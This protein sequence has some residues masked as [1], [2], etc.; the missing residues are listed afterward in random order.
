VAVRHAGGAS[1]GRAL[2][3]QDAE[4]RAR[5]RR[6]VMA[7]RGRLR[8]AL[9]DAAQAVTFGIRAAGRAMLRR[10]GAYER[11]QLR[12]LHA[13]RRDGHPGPARRP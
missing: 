4:M 11:A 12:A 1:V 5:R 3:G 13:A 2:Q 6:E 9:D 8:L 10:G 7:D